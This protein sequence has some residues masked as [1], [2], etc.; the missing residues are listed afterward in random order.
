MAKPNTEKAREWIRTRRLALGLT[1]VELQRR[2]GL[3]I[4]T[5]ERVNGASFTSLRV[6]ANVLGEPSQ[7]VWQE[8]IVRRVRGKEHKTALSQWIFESRIRLH[9]TQQELASLC[10]ITQTAIGQWENERSGCYPS[11]LLKLSKVLGPAPDAVVRESNFYCESPHPGKT[12][13]S[14]RLHQARKTANV[15][16]SFAAGKIDVKPNTL[17]C[18][19]Q[20]W[21]NPKLENVLKAADVYN[22]SLDWLLDR[23][24]K[25]AAPKAA[26]DVDPK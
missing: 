4:H 5:L 15:N 23:E 2:T 10:G 6:L 14:R 12:E 19:E 20:G 26:A 9:L 16:T 25:V 22:V 13:L 21:R 7:E 8:A 24:E 3:H 11:T 17:T 18:W 1:Q